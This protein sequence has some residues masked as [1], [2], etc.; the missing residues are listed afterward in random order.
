[1]TPEVQEALCR[2]LLTLADDEL[3]IGLRD[4]EWTGIAP[5]VEEDVAFSSL[6]QDE[7]GHARLC[8]TLA[9]ELTGSDADH[10]AYLRPK[11]A[12]YHA[13]VLE[14]RATLMYGPEGQHSGKVQWAKAVT[15]RFLYD[16]FDN[17]RLEALLTSSYEPLANAMRKVYREE[18]YHLW[19]GEAWW[20]TLAG[21]STLARDH[22][23]TALTA[24]WPGVLGFFEDAPGE[25]LLQ[26]EGVIATRTAQLLSP[27]LERVQP[28]F[29]QYQLPFPVHKE[30]ENWTLEV[31]PLMGGR[32][33]QH[34]AGW[35]ELYEEM[36][37]VRRLEPEGT[38]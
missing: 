38:W 2:Y 12:Y 7:L 26:T 11:D 20:K 14:E 21:S 3:V 22:L 17:L 10:L 6:A 27:W 36:T 5:M 37:M 19:H 24:T 8:Y 9:A 35:D 29:T 1:M 13:R 30:G 34:G 15:R 28:Y 16:L 31:E 25:T 32:L 18:R 23:E 4:A 33:G